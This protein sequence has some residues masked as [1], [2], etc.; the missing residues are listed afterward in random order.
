LDPLDL[1]HHLCRLD[2][3]DLLGRLDHRDLGYLGVF[4]A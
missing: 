3:V 1:E 4:L 2:L